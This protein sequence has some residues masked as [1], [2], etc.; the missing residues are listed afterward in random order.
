LFNKEIF[1]Q[2]LIF[3][4]YILLI[5]LRFYDSD[6]YL[7]CFDAKERIEEKTQHNK[8]IRNPPDSAIEPKHQNRKKPTPRGCVLLLPLRAHEAAVP[9]E[10]F[11]GP[12]A[13]TGRQGASSPELT[14]DLRGGFGERRHG[15]VWYWG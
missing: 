12:I 13:W 4:V 5:S 9:G 10:G 14:G 8:G 2:F 6:L 11:L 3:V 1:F 7:Y 15:W